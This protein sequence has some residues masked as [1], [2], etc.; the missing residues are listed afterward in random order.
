MIEHFDCLVS[1][2]VVWLLSLQTIRE[3]EKTGKVTAGRCESRF[4]FAKR[5]A[6]YVLLLDDPLSIMGLRE[7]VLNRS[8]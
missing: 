8:E 1:N 4:L 7:Y 2:I 3:R 6:A 5:G